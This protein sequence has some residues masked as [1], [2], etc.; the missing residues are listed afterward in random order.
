MFIA[1]G[2]FGVPEAVS[3]QTREK[4]KTKDAETVINWIKKV[5]G[6]TTKNVH[7]TLS[8]TR[9]AEPIYFLNKEIRWTPNLGIEKLPS[10]TAPMG[11]VTDFASIPPLFFSILRPDGKYAYGA[12]LHDYLYWEQ[13]VTR[14]T[15]DR[16][17]WYAMLEF[18]VAKPKA[19]LIY[20]A[21]RA[22]GWWA[23]RQNANSKKNGEK[24]V[25]QLFPQDPKMTWEEWKRRPG[26]FSD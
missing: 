25:L 4:Y 21:V 5:P 3:D 6:A 13:N 24:R 11:F 23:W 17:L 7:G 1:F 20:N 16:I 12:V 26:V 18:E 22:G 10:V 15:A 9:F 2:P 19:L 14:K 8:I